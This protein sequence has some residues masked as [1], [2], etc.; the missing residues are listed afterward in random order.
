[1]AL[2]DL[3][4]DGQYELYY[5]FSWGSGIPRSEVGYFDPADKEE[6]L[7]EESFFMQELILTV[8]ESGNLCVNTS[9]LDMDS[10][11]E[12]TS[13]PQ[14]KLGTIGLEGNQIVLKLF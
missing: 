10:S 6:V 9:S 2:A 12:F 4:R 8:E 7:F 11:V 1:M 13:K 3:N 5:T 14:D